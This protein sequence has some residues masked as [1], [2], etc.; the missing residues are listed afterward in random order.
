MAPKKN[1]K[2]DKEKNKQPQKKPGRKL[3]TAQKI[4]NIDED[5]INKIIEEKKGELVL[6]A[7]KIAKE[8]VAKIDLQIDSDALTDNQKLAAKMFARGGSIDDIAEKFGLTISQFEQWL[9][10][11]AFFKSINEYLFDSTVVNKNERIRQEAYML[12][13]IG[14]EIYKRIED[15]E[16]SNMQLSS[17]FKLYQ[18]HSRLLAEKVDKTEEKDGTK[19]VSVLIVNYFKNEKGK[20]YDGLEQFLSDPKFNFNNFIDVESEEA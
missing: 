4:K 10:N 7:D 19:D 3:T 15:N 12:E 8:M 1:D 14:Q 20:D 11:P 13:K 18:D 16:L 6:E 17:L 9:K 5:V 2:N